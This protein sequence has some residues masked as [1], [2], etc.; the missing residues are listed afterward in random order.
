MAIANSTAMN[1]WV[2]IFFRITVLGFFGYI[3]RSI[4]T[5]S[6][7]SFIFNFFEEL[8]TI[9]YSGCTNLHSIQ[10]CMNVLFLHIFTNTFCWLIYWLYHSHRHVVISHC[11]FNLHFSD[12]Q[13]Y[14]VS[15]HMSFGHLCAL[16]GEL[17]IQVFCPFLTWIVCSF[18]VEVYKFL[19][20]FRY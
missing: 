3:P 1:R 19:I 13:W 4:I 12:D 20:N 9:F 8:H 7:G 16:F 17:S 6:W 11:G 18:V 2:H 10:Q 5:G 15:F 14:W